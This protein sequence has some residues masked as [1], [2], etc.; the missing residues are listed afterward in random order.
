MW[1]EV[2]GLPGVGK[3]TLI[4]NNSSSIPK[5]YKIIRSN[6]ARLLQRIVSKLYL[7]FIFGPILKNQRAA[8]KLAYRMGFRVFEDKNSYVF[9][10]DSGILQA[11]LEN[12]LEREFQNV[13]R[14]LA[15]M[16]HLSMPD[17][18]IYIKDDIQKIVE[19]EKGRQNPRFDF[20][21]NETIRL[22]ELAEKF[23][24]KELLQ[25]VKLVDTI[26]PDQIDDFEKA[27]KS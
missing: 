13:D 26:R 17:K 12:I 21:F 15:V 8:Q 14:N 5:S 22:Y 4:E 27:F 24:E 3:T 23:I 25:H 6:Q 7:I 11:V 9:F 19:R 16:P 10:Y 2:I 18:V 1:I 20:N